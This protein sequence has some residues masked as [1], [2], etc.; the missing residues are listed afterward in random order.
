MD[1]LKPGTIVGSPKLHDP[2]RNIRFGVV[3]APPPSERVQRILSDDPSVSRPAIAE[4]VE[5]AW[6]KAI[7]DRVT[8]DR[9]RAQLA[10]WGTLGPNGEPGYMKRRP[11]AFKPGG[12]RLDWEPLSPE[13]LQSG[14]WIL[15]I[16]GDDEDEQNHREK[17][18]SGDDDL[19]TL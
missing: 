2:A 4:A 10:R 6:P 7:K 14:L 17:W 3:Q 15:D 16:P 19:E 18:V 12:Y 11:D 13:R 9:V 1:S 8:A 5:A